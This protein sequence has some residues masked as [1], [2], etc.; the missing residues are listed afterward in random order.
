VPFL[1]LDL[2]SIGDYLVRMVLTSRQLGHA[3]ISGT[4]GEYSYT[5]GPPEYEFVRDVFLR[6]PD[7]IADIW[8]GG[9]RNAA[10]FTRVIRESTLPL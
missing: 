6:S 2:A 9:E 7:E 1:D 4:V 5:G 8:F 3:H 10:Q